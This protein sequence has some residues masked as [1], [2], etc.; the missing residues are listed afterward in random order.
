MFTILKE[1]GAHQIYD[2]AINRIKKHGFSQDQTY[3]PYSEEIDI[4]GAILLA[5]G[6][7]EKLLKTGE[8]EPE[9]CGVPP[10]LCSRARYFCEY[11]ELIVHKEISEWCASHSK[12][13]AINLLRLASDR[14]AITF[15]K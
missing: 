10:Y 8:T 5:C 14:V 1:L 13:E 12:T 6:G 7:K 11:L 4:W 9:N 3:D 15:S 2:D